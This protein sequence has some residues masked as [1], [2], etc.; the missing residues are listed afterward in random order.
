MTIYGRF[1][2]E[3]FKNIVTV[4]RMGTLEDVR[5]LDK[6]RPDGIDKKAVELGSYVV[7]K[8]HDGRNPG[9]ERLYHISYLRADGGWGEISDAIDAAKAKAPAAAPPAAFERDQVVKEGVSLG[10][11][12][13]SGKT[14]YDV[15]WIGGSTSR[16]RYAAKRDVHVA[17][18]FELEGQDRVVR[19]LRREA[20]AARHE[21]KVGARCKR[22]QVHPSR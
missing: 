16:Y 12:L 4:E 7:V 18:E 19:H 5:K 10:L 8:E 3:E 6:R 15:V 14:S 20:V 22:G 2:C 1:H 17:T 21:R 13:Q 9:Q 11:V